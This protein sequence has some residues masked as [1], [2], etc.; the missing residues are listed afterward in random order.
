M[1]IEASIPS[2][3]KE[4]KSAGI[5]AAIAWHAV[6][7]ALPFGGTGI[8]GPQGDVGPALIHHDQLLGVALLH[9]LAKARSFLLVAFA[10]CQRLFFRVQP[11]RSISRLIVEVLT[12][13]PCSFSQS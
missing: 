2:T 1:I 5:L 3:V 10:G 8:Q 11:T 6:P 7:G 13:M 12:R 4:A 9:V